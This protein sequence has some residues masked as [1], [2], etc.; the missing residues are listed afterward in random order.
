VKA[1]NRSSLLVIF[2]PHKPVL[3]PTATAPFSILFNT[4]EATIKRFSYITTGLSPVLKKP[5][6]TTKGQEKTK[7]RAK[8]EQPWIVQGSIKNYKQEQKPTANSNT[9]K[10]QLISM[11]YS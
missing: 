3:R 9:Y 11:T 1:F 2:F 8:Q 10:Q 5:H 7:S 6:P 4:Q